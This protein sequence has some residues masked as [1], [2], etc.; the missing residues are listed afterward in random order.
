MI[1][2]ATA[3]AP[4]LLSLVTMSAIKVRG[5]G[6]WPNA[7][8]LIDVED[9]GWRALHQRPGHQFLIDIEGPQPQLLERRRVPN[10]HSDQRKQQQ[11]ADAATRSEFLRPT[12]YSFHDAT[13][14]SR[15]KSAEL[16]RRVALHPG[17]RC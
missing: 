16:D 2:K 11:D 13:R 12:P 3:A 8:R 15:R 6:H 10:P 14:A 7:T 5:E 1:S 9:Y 17:N 4:S